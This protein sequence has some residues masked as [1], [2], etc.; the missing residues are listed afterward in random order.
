MNL[1]APIKAW[2]FEHHSYLFEFLWRL[3]HLFEYFSLCNRKLRIWRLLHTKAWRLYIFVILTS[4]SI[5]RTA[6]K[7]LNYWRRKHNRVLGQVSKRE[8]KIFGAN[9][10]AKSIENGMLLVRR[11]QKW[12]S[13]SWDFKDLI[14]LRWS[15]DLSW[16]L[17][18]M[19]LIRF[20]EVASET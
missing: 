4:C 12:V 10:Q 3:F 7:I 14:C 17:K 2:C 6:S 16:G 1:L 11:G 13:K 5:I 20:G 9:V 19:R 15:K 18:L 8:R